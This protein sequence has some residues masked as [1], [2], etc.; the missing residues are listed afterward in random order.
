MRLS[1]A[2]LIITG[3]KF[4]F[5]QIY[6]YNPINK[7]F[8]QFFPIYGH[9][10]LKVKKY[11][12]H[13]FAPSQIRVLDRFPHGKRFFS[14]YGKNLWPCGKFNDIDAKHKQKSAIFPVRELAKDR[15][16]NNRG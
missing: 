6:K 13:R 3:P 1:G 8:R 12:V 2:P 11:R 14:P 7:F 9:L 4:L 5:R 10:T 15:L 16:C